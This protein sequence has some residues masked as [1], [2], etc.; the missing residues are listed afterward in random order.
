[1][2]PPDLVAKLNECAKTNLIGTRDVW[3]SR[4]SI[5]SW[6]VILG[7]VLEG[8]ELMYDMLSI[9]RSNI[10]R[11]RYS[12]ILLE[13]HVER[14]KV[15]AFIGWILIIGGLLGELR[16]GSKIVSLSAS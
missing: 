8:P 10:Q 4:Q 13:N 11:F 14:A 7:L 12:I 6:A 16:A 2:L 1:M 3:F 9:V 5:F 15:A